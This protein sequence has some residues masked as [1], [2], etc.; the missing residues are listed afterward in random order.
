MYPTSTYIVSYP[1]CICT[2]SPGAQIFVI[3]AEWLKRERPISLNQRRALRTFHVSRR[4]E[5]PASKPTAF[6][7][8]DCSHARQAPGLPSQSDVNIPRNLKHRSWRSFARQRENHNEYMSKYSYIHISCKM[9]KNTRKMLMKDIK[10][11]ASFHAYLLCT[12]YYTVSCT[13]GVFHE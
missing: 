10:I 1:R 12:H 5:T 13:K 11:C 2:K 9:M 6:S 7:H 8:R 3:P 4:L